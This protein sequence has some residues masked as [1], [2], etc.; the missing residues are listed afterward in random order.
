LAGLPPCGCLAIPITLNE[1]P[2]T[3]IFELVVSLFCLA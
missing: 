2:P 3:L 1:V